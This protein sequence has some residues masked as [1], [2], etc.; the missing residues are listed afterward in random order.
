M[1]QEISR[2]QS[3]TCPVSHR[4]VVT[5][6]PGPSISATCGNDRDKH[7][8]MQVLLSNATRNTNF[9]ATKSNLYNHDERMRI[10]RLI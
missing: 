8:L 9:G 2:D 10:V 6:C 1:N 4:H 7:C 5:T 3:R